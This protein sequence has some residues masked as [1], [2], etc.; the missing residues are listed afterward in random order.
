VAVNEKLINFIEG[1][2]STHHARLTRIIRKH[3]RNPG[4]R[5][6]D[7]LLE[8]LMALTTAMESGARVAKGK[9]P[10][11]HSPDLKGNLLQDSR[12]GGGM[13]GR[14]EGEEDPLGGDDPGREDRD[15]GDGDSGDWEDDGGSWGESQW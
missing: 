9:K 12:W 11:P 6:I 5:A 8:A 10:L 7:D 3:R 4:P 1:P 2:L 14:A 13:F 15:W